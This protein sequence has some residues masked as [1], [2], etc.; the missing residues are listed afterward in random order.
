MGGDGQSTKASGATEQAGGLRGA[1]RSSA[2][3]IVVLQNADAGSACQPGAIEAAFREAGV[4][5]EVRP[6]EGPALRDAA[7]AAA[8]EADVV[9]AA[10]GDGTVNA[11]ASALAGTSTRMGVLPLGTLN[12]FARDLGIPLDLREAARVVAAGGVRRVDVA[13]VN[14]HAFVNNSSVGFYPHVVRQRS[15]LRA[16]L[17]KWLAMAWSVVAVVW[18]LPRMR[19]RLRTEQLEAPVV[20]PFLFVGNNRYEP[21]LVA[22][23]K[24]EALDRGELRIYVARWAGRLGFIRVALRW[25]VGRGRGEDVSE[26]SARSVRV[27]SRRSELHV[28]ADGEVLKLRP[29]LRY[30]IHPRALQVLAP[31]PVA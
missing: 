22:E 9:V 31:E 7:A 14:G 19:L 30:V 24:R 16:W 12:H 26:L 25:F 4:A 23:R 1:G 11:V 17:G 27:D 3:R 20:T 29:P 21:A 15:R 8:R 13:E 10:G 28:A 5:A 18:R 6:V 2:R